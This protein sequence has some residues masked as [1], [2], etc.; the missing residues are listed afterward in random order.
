MTLCS[1]PVSLNSNAEGVVSVLFPFALPKQNHPEHSAR[2][3]MTAQLQPFAATLS[4]TQLQVRFRWLNQVGFVLAAILASSIT[5]CSSIVLCMTG[6]PAIPAHRVPREFLARPRANMQELTMSRMRQ[7][8]PKVYQLGPNDVLGIYIENVLGQPDS[9]PPVHFSQDNSKPPSLGFPIPVREDGTLALPLVDPINVSGLTL[10]QAADAIRYAFTVKKRI[11]PEG[12]D[13]ILVTLQRPRE[14]RVLVVR[15]DAGSGGAAGAIGGAGTGAVG[16]A[17]GGLGLGNT[18]RGSGSTVSLPAYENDLLT[19][20]SKTGGLPGLDAKNEVLILRGNFGDA[21]ERD[22][23]IAKLKASQDPCECKMDLPP[24]AHIVKIPLRFQPED[25]PKFKEEDIILQTG[26][27]VF[28]QSREREIYYTSGAIR[29]GVQLLPRDID[30]D[31]LQAVALS[32]GNIAMGATG[33]QS[34]GGGGGGGG[35]SGGG[36]TSFGATPSRA[37][38]LRKTCNGGEIPI[39]VDLRRALITPSER[40][41]IAPEDTIIVQYTFAEELYN[42]ALRMIQFN[43]LFSGLSGKGV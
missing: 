16:G 35:N 1:A 10:T 26:D 15:E 19:A 39:K 14:Y 27:I 7:T 21:V 43:F 31:I 22:L 3:C 9:A 33:V 20:L 29:S 36:G 13:R 2:R 23:L 42:A 37:I 12:K 8:P 5:G 41:L 6:I 25:F 11:L 4:G 30:I 18:R 24:D 34:I 32:G 28:V 40:I 38:V 17:G